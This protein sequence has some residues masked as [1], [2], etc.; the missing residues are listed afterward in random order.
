MRSLL[1]PRYRIEQLRIDDEEGIAMWNLD[2]FAAEFGHKIYR[3]FPIF[4]VL[5]EGEL[6]A[7]YYAQA[8]VA[9]YPAVH[10]G[11]FTPRSFLSVGQTIVAASKKVFGNPLWIVDRKTPVLTPEH[12]RKVFLIRQ[13]VDMYE[14]P[15]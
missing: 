6:A 9:I 10:P 11:K 5:V 13:N 1:Q 2:E 3:V 8:R 14:V 7:Y 15:D 12:L 4:V